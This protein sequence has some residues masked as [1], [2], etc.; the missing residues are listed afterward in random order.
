MIES[1]TN[2]PPSVSPHD[3][4]VL[5]LV[6]RGMS[7][8]KIAAKLGISEKTV[9]TQTLMLRARLGVKS[10]RELEAAARRLGLI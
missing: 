9:Q 10:R 5:L 8:R 4:E 3:R 7:D 1:N 6:C 2:K